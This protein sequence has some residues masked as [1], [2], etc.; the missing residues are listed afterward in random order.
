MVRFIRS[1]VVVALVLGV[2]VPASAQR[3]AATDDLSLLPVDSELVA[4]L[5][6]RKLV[7]STL[8]KQF[9][10]PKLS[11][12][13]VKKALDEFRTTCGLDATKVVT[14]LAIGVKGLGEDQPDVVIVAHGVPKAKLI[15]CYPKL[16]K[17]N[18][19]TVKLDGDVLLMKD[20]SQRAAVTFLD[21][22][23]ALLVFGSKASTAGVKAIARGK[24]ALKTSGAFLG[25]YRKLNTNHTLWMVVNG[26]SKAFSQLGA[27]G[28]KPKAV[29]GS[30]NVT[31][32]L[33]LD[34]RMALGSEDQAKNFANMLQ[35][36]MKAAAM[37]FDKIDVKADG[38]DMRVTV[39]LSDA[40]LR[41]LAKQFGGMIKP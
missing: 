40:K 13:D 3:K 15:A 5:D 36:Q 41:G 20:G 28:L 19:A 27:M 34:L 12:G 11:Q 22:R 10:S 4:G 24:S 14:K 17:K 29:Y 39:L 32:N 33:T 23:T 6:F 25:F 35:G 9:I 2:A 26:N 1:F 7:S 31:K 16:S 37:M 21:A 8:W 18:K 38:K 30:V